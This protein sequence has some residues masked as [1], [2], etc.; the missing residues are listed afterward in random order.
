V[1][2]V[3]AAVEGRWPL[4]Q[5]QWKEGGRCYHSSGRKVAIACP[6]KEDLQLIVTLLGQCNSCHASFAVLNERHIYM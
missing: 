4:L 6:V 3:T 1:A 2:V 5:Q